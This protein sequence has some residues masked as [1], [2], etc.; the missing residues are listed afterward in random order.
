[1]AIA[2][3]K[4]QHIGL[5]RSA[6]TSRPMLLLLLHAG[7]APNDLTARQMCLLAATST[8]AIQ[9][10]TSLNIVVGDLRGEFGQTPLHIATRIR[11]DLAILSKLVDCGVDLE[12]T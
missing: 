4:W 5:S 1:M 10:L 3:F 6:M 8:A 2:R 7:A 11:A 12:G 9:V